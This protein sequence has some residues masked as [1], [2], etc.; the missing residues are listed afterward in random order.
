MCGVAWPLWGRGHCRLIIQAVSKQRVALCDRVSGFIWVEAD[1]VG[2]CGMA[3][4]AEVAL[5]TLWEPGRSVHGRRERSRR[6][7][8]RVGRSIVGMLARGRKRVPRR[9]SC[10]L[11]S[12]RCEP[13]PVY[14]L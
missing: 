6:D 14:M 4:V 1:P 8:S 10:G 11:M 5:R 12:L 13:D 2:V 7:Q 3:A 9:S